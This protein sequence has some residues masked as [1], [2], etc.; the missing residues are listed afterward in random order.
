MLSAC[1]SLARAW[2]FPKPSVDQETWRS[3][4]RND[5][6]NGRKGSAG[7]LL[8]G[9]QPY[10]I[11]MTTSKLYES[12]AIYG[13]AALCDLRAAT[14]RYRTRQRSFCVCELPVPA[15]TLRGD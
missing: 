4:K 2:C 11:A 5:E 9:K 12:H 10:E 1:R 7:E 8:A 6:T 3:L 13:N 15:L 14:R